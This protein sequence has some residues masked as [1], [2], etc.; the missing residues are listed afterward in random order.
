MPEEINDK[1]VFTLMQVMQSIKKTLANRY[2][3]AF[4]I[5][6]E[7][8]KLNYYPHSG[9][10]YPDLVEKE[11]GKLIAQIRSVLWK[12]DYLRINRAFQSTVKEPL[13]DG[14]KILFCA[15]I[16][17]DPSYGL[18][19]RIIDIDPGFS[20][21]DLEQEKAQSIAKL[22]QDGIYG[23]NKLFKLPLLPKRIAIISVDTSKGFADFMKVI[24]GNEWGYRFSFKLF[25]ALLQ[26]EKAINSLI[27]QLQQIKKLYQQFDVVAIIRGGGGDIGL[28]C[29]NDFH[30]SKEVALFP[31]PVITGI[32]HSTNETV[33]E[34]LA[35]E[36]AITPTKL[37]EFLIQKFHN[38][39]VPV[40]RAEEK[41]IRIS[42]KIL[43]D[44]QLKFHNATRY[45]RLVTSNLLTNG[46]N[47]VLNL[48]N[49]LLQQSKFL[50]KSQT[51]E[52]NNL[53]R[54]INNLSPEN[55]LKRGYS[56]TLLNGKAIRS[57][58]E[59]KQGERLETMVIDGVIQS[60]VVS[61]SKVG[62]L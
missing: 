16:T 22:K 33:V 29:Y 3:S 60:D 49:A 5:K 37:A 34:M 4:W 58:N 45:F 35:F 42:R 54:T 6:V 31:L 27:N 11:N 24:E 53:E 55:V 47:T 56:I 38:Y 7:M 46:N 23:N 9:H 28:S 39:S 62:E 12:D 8:N 15:T 21:G 2:T 52:L 61:I 48:R 32:G 59:V 25:P 43:K 36:N 18:S 20:L 30:L 1:K 14:I 26:G 57:Y 19:L 51:N 50:F 41:L 40:H 17:F 44:E 10:C 13:K